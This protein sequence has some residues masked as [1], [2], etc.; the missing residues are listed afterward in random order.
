MRPQQGIK[1][2]RGFNPKEAKQ[3]VVAPPKMSSNITTSL[4]IKVAVD[5]VAVSTCLLPTVSWLLEKGV[6]NQLLNTGINANDVSSTILSFANFLLQGLQNFSL[7][8]EM[9]VTTV[10]N[11]INVLFEAMKPKEIPFKTGTIN[12]SWAENLSLFLPPVVPGPFSAFVFGDIVDTG[13]GSDPI[14]AVATNPGNQSDF[15]LVVKYFSQENTDTEMVPVGTPAPTTK[16]GAAFARQYVYN[17]VSVSPTGGWF[18]DIESE[19]PF[20][21]PMFARFVQYG[22][23]MDLRVSRFL[24]SSSGDSLYSMGLP[25][26]PDFTRPLY[27]NRY[28]A[29]FKCIDVNLIANWL[30]AWAVLAR[31]S[32]LRTTFDES[33]T[34]ITAPFSFSQ[35][36]FFVVVRQALCSIFPTQKL[37]QFLAPMN[38][39]ETSSNNG[40][41]PLVVHFGTYGNPVFKDLYI[42]QFLQE[43]L[44]ALKMRSFRPKT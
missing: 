14:T 22:T 29:V 12:Y 3:M 27:K 1:E 28:P 44:G 18:C 26:L 21:C 43:N 13:S 40:F 30:C 31:E 2:G 38:F 4:G 36:D 37:V 25:L 17:G 32:F 15:N 33:D 41:V 42:P 16:D 9:T 10:P 5:N 8:A 7:G 20:K 39:T 23:G 19:V 35:Q 11:Y 24:E 6:L 34:I